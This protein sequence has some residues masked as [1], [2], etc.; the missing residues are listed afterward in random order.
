ML[1]VLEDL[2]RNRYKKINNH[3]SHILTKN[4]PC[5]FTIKH[6]ENLLYLDDLKIYGVTFRFLNFNNQLEKGVKY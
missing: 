5:F 6:H 4:K 1:S 2:C 3:Y